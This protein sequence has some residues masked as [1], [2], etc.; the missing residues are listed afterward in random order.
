MQIELGFEE[1]HGA[2]I[3]LFSLRRCRHWRRRRCCRLQKEGTLERSWKRYRITGCSMHG[4][5]CARSK[6]LSTIF[7]I[8]FKY[9]SIPMLKKTSGS[10][11]HVY[12]VKI[13]FGSRRRHHFCLSLSFEFLQSARR[14]CYISVQVDLKYIPNYSQCQHLQYQ[15]R[16]SAL[17]LEMFKT[18]KRAKYGGVAAKNEGA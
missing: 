18:K 11:S 4:A 1:K 12:I 7:S 13:D 17:L 2:T 15:I 8:S 10:G 6:R 14:V 5:A 16:F 3:T 9:I